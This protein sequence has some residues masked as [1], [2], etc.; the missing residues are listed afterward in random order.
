ML[1][2]TTFATVILPLSVGDLT[3]GRQTAVR[4]VTLG[5]RRGE[6]SGD[7]PGTALQHAK[8]SSHRHNSLL[9]I[10]R[11]LC[12]SLSQALFC[13]RKHDDDEKDDDGDDNDE[14]DRGVGWGAAE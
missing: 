10:E 14:D 3:K 6:L 2:F 13:A 9:H 8:S 12:H 7:S 1:C 11:W 4:L 5:G